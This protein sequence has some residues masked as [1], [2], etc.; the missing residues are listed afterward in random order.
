MP[1]GR[2][3]GEPRK[4]KAKS[5]QLRK[6][7]RAAT[8]ASKGAVRRLRAKKKAEQTELKAVRAHARLQVLNLM[9]TTMS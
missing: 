6:V 8:P 1:A 2:K 4:T 7:K 5:K 9:T 3:P